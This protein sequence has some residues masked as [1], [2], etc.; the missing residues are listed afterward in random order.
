MLPEYQN[1]GACTKALEIFIEYIRKNN[2]DVRQIKLCINS[3]NHASQRVAYK[4]E[5]E[6][7]NKNEFAEDW[8]YKL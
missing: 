1:M 2:P 3:L 8:Q 4:S 7:V 5:F 6:I